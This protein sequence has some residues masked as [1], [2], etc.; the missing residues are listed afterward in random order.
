MWL[1]SFVICFLLVNTEAEIFLLKTAYKG[2]ALG[3]NQMHKWF[4]C[5]KSGEMTIGDKPRPGRPSAS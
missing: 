3:E 1:I 5:S 4:F 2:D